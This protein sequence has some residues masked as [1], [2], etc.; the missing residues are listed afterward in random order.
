MCQEVLEAHTVFMTPLKVAYDEESGAWGNDVALEDPVQSPCS[1]L[2][3][4]ESHE[5]RLVSTIPG[6]SHQLDKGLYW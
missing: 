1:K 4:P 6:Q 2:L 5:L 3:P